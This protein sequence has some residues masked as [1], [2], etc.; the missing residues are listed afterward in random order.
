MIQ[1]NSNTGDMYVWNIH[2]PRGTPTFLGTVGL[3]WQFSGVGNFSSVPG[4]TDLLLRNVN[5]GG[6]ELYDINIFNRLTGTF[7]LG[8]VGIDWQYA[9]IAPIRA[10]LA[11]ATEE[12]FDLIV[13]G[14]RGRGLSRAVL[15]SVATELSSH[16]KLPVLLAGGG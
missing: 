8:Q 7:F 9:G 3:D 4:E 5:D 15:G 13:V 1:R 14:T 2:D 16:S 12:G 6:L 11:K 10:L